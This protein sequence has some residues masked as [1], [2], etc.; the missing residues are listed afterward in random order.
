[1][2]SR[3]EIDR[4]FALQK[5]QH[6]LVRNTSAKARIEK[7]KAFWRAI[8]SRIPELNHA[9][10]EDLHKSPEEIGLTELFPV[11]AEV[12]HAVRQL[13][14]WMTPKQVPNPIAFL[15]A[16]GQIRYE[17]RGVSLI[18]SPWNFPFQLTVG[19]LISAIAAGNCVI[20]KPSEVSNH[21]SAF[22]RD[23]I[24]STFPENEVAVFEGDQTVATALLEKP[25][26]HIFFTGSPAVGSIVMQAAA[27]Q[28]IPVTL[29]LGGKS[30]V[31]I[32]E[33]ADI[34]DAARKIVWGKYLN[35]G[36]ACVAPDYV[37]LPKSMKQPFIQAAKDAILREYPDL[38]TSKDYCAIINDRHFARVRTLLESAVK[39]GATVD[40]GGIVEP[41]KRYIAPTILSDLKKDSLIL[42]QEIFGPLL[43]VITYEKIEEALLFIRELERPLGLYIFSSND[44]ATE[45]ILNNTYSGAA[46]INDVVNYFANVE[47]PFGGMNHSGHGN[48]HGFYGFRAFSHERAVLRQPK[49]A[50]MRFL[51]PPYTP[52]VKNMIDWTWRFFT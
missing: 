30:P 16:H 28:L 51:Y 52:K 50:M 18:L 43:P 23:L 32:H 41:S 7:L 8:E 25:F 22:I 14:T 3:A 37:M 39:E 26:D 9:V 10:F 49:F 35:A 48:S 33:S 36:Q 6:L 12:K 34:A 21:T 17:P 31:I 44:T 46:A 29:E 38:Q 4:I 5:Q 15:G 11:A 27:R 2:D 42:K 47:L 45:F 20:V 13:K 40:A 1:M 24:H 19:P